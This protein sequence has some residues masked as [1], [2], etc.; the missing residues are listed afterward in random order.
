[1]AADAIVYLCTNS[2]GVWWAFGTNGLMS[3][4]FGVSA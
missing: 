3:T 4:A 2:R 1:M